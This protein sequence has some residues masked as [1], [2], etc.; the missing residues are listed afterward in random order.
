MSR[1]SNDEEELDD[2]S[3]SINE[4][5]VVI[6]A[7]RANNSS[8]TASAYIPISSVRG[9]FKRGGYSSNNGVDPEIDKTTGLTSMTCLSIAIIVLVSIGIGIAIYY[10]GIAPAYKTAYGSAPTSNSTSV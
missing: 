8:S 2:L 3:G 10:F 5:E 4:D 9:G 7:R 1:Y 6:V